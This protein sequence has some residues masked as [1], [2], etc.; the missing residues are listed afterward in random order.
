MEPIPVSVLRIP[1]DGAKLLNMTGVF[2]AAGH[3]ATQPAAIGGVTWLV[4][5]A[6]AAAGAWARWVAPIAIALLYLLL[7][8]GS[9]HSAFHGSGTVPWIFVLAAGGF[10]GW[11]LGGRTVLRHIGEREYRN[12]IAS[13]KGISSIWGAWFRD[14]T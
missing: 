5:I 10:V 12:R 4:A 7:H 1:S 6:A 11:Q 14:P 13:A 9:G 2:L 3:V 8:T